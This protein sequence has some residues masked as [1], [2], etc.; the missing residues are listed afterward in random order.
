MVNKRM[1]VNTSAVPIICSV[2][3]RSPKIICAWRI[4]D[5]GPM[6]EMIATLFAPIFFRAND[7]RN[8]ILDDKNVFIK[9]SANRV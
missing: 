8:V 4:V 5:T 2:K 6:L 1:P 7:N 9:Y 3:M